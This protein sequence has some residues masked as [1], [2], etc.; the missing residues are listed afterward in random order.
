MHFLMKRRRTELQLF[1]KRNFKK[2]DKIIGHAQF[3]MTLLQD[4]YKV[5]KKI[6][7]FIRAPTT[8]PLLGQIYP[9]TAF[10]QSQSH[11]TVPLRE[12]DT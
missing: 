7:L 6:R 8:L 9:A 10:S 2:R 11:A 12:I 5:K 3:M 1:K 4:L